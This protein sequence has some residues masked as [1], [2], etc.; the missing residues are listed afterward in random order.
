MN[1]KT[2]ITEFERRAAIARHDKPGAIDVTDRVMSRLDRLKGP[3]PLKSPFLL[4]SGASALAACLAAAT[5]VPT[6]MSWSDPMTQFMLALG[7]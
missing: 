7:I 3:S 5:Y 2:D 4:M 6:L 1:I